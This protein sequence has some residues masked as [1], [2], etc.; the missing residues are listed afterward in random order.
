M[1]TVIPL[2]ARSKAYVCGLSL[3]GTAGSN[4]AGGKDI[5]LL[6][7]LWAA[8]G[9]NLWQEPIIRPGESV[10]VIACNNKLLHLQ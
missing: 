10:C 7:M 9:R 2:V 3:A 5:C 4:P 1:Y 8:A 6:G